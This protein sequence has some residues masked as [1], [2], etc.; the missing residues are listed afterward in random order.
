MAHP[1]N[2]LHILSLVQK[3]YPDK[4]VVYNTYAHNY[5]TLSDISSLR[6]KLLTVNS[7]NGKDN[8]YLIIQSTHPQYHHMTIYE[9]VVR[10]ETTHPLI[11]SLPYDSCI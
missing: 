11:S 8:K 3:D 7:I 1:I 6:E 9:Y 10:N 4:I 2:N 5:Y